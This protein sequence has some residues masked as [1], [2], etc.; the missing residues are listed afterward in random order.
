MQK[1]LVIAV[2]GLHRG[3]WPQSGPPVI[4]S[5]RRIYSSIV[6][7]GLS[8]DPLESGLFSTG[9]DS[10]DTAFAMPFPHTGP[11]AL[12]DR[13]DEIRRRYPLDIIIPCVD[14][15][16]P[17]YL[18]LVDELRA[19]KIMVPLPTAAAFQRRSKDRLAQLGKDVGV[20]VPPTIAAPDLDTAYVACQ[21]LGY[22]LYLKGLFY[23]AVLVSRP[24]EVAGAFNLLAALWGLPVIAQA[25]IRGD[26]HYAVTGLG[27]GKGGVIGFCAIR[28]VMP[29]ATGKAFTGIAVADPVLLKHMK[30]IVKVLQWNGPFELEFIKSQR[31]Y[32]LFEIN[33]R[34]PAWIDFPSQIGCNLPAAL[35]TMLTG[36]KPSPVAACKP[37]R[38]FVRHS[39]DLVGDITQLA[40]MSVTGIKTLGG[41]IDVLSPDHQQ[42]TGPPRYGSAAPFGK[43]EG[44]ALRVHPQH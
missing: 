15:E 6:I 1:P 21:R 22:P 30:H 29:T 17:H 35:L 18:A 31:G 5:I 4:R 36:A 11:H 20:A 28:K 38:L 25:C 44:A 2:S 24:G 42:R 23:D 41:N 27:D 9:D 39:I 37:G 16:L 33:P 34:F 43:P 32:E 14:T 13:L 19:R 8:Y 10:V 26:E 12:L 3:E 40:A 7:V